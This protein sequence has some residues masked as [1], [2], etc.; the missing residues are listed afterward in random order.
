MYRKFISSRSI[1]QQPIFLGHNVKIY[2]MSHLKAYTLID[3]D[4]VIGYPVRVKILKA[5]EDSPIDD[6]DSVLDKL[7]SG[8]SIG[9]KSIIRRCT[10]IYEDV[11]LEDAVEVGHNVVIREK[12]VIRSGCKIGTGTVI[13]GDVVIG[14]NTIIQSYV[15]IPPGV[16]IG[17]NVF[18]APR[19]VFTNDRYPP[20]KR[21]AETV[22]EDEVVVGAN[23]VITPGVVIGKGAVIAAGAVVTK[24]I[25]PYTVVAGAPAK[26]IMSREEY[27]QKKKRYEEEYVFPYR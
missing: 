9:G 20:S 6:V 19:V 18:I 26:P 7:S 22:I 12:T 24:S 3:N 13:D 15:Y 1:I 14:R 4:V 11:V 25:K 16:R 23:A 17:N 8:T 5:I 27:E 21:L 10:T 2:G